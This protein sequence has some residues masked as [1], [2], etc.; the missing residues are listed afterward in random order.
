MPKNTPTLEQ[1]MRPQFGLRAMLVVVT[2]LS[3]ALGLGGWMGWSDVFDFAMLAT[4]Y[5]QVHVTFWPVVMAVLWLF[6]ADAKIYGRCVV[7]L[8]ILFLSHLTAA[9]LFVEMLCHTTWDLYPFNS[10]TGLIVTTLNW[11]VP[12]AA[13]GVAVGLCFGLTARTTFPYLLGCFLAALGVFGFLCFAVWLDSSRL[14]SLTDSVW[15]L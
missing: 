7:V 4:W 6:G 8:G 13:I 11:T 15:W 9:I 10:H 1:P 14:Y 5:V 3:L 12:S 2:L